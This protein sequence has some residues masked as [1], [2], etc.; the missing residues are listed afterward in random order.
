MPSE[1]T[2]WLA[3][4]FSLGPFPV[5]GDGVTVNNSYYRH[6]RPYDQVVGASVRM[7]ITLGDPIRSR[8][9]IVPGQAGNPVSAHYRDQ[10]QSW[11][12]GGTIPS[13]ESEEEME[14]WPLLV[15]AARPLR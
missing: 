3:P 7:L 1:T 9:V 4:F 6:S 8:F 15:L 12:T 2:K 5:D 14:V 10:V 11:R 13:A